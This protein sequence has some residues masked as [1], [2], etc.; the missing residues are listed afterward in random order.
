MPKKKP[1]SPVE[2]CACLDFSCSRE[3]VQQ[4]SYVVVVSQQCSICLRLTSLFT[5]MSCSPSTGKCAI[6][7]KVWRPDH[8]SFLIQLSKKVCQSI[9]HSK[10]ACLT[11]APEC[12]CGRRLRDRWKKT[13]ICMHLESI[14]ML[15]SITHRLLLHCQR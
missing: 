13:S 5:I 7:R 15:C 12:I 11:K 14:P 8:Q 2:P 4:T 10:R 9:G 3:Q 6:Q 1:L